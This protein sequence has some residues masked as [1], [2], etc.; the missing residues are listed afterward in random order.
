MPRRQRQKSAFGVHLQL[1]A[2]HRLGHARRDVFLQAVRQR[3]E[4]VVDTLLLDDL[5]QEL[6]RFPAVVLAQKSTHGLERDI[7]LEIQVHVVDE[8]PDQ[9][10]HATPPWGARTST[11]LSYSPR[12]NPGARS[13]RTFSPEPSRTFGG[14]CRSGRDGGC[15][16]AWPIH[17]QF[18]SAI[19]S[20]SWQTRHGRA[21]RR[22]AAAHSPTKLPPCGFTESP[23]RPVDAWQIA[24]SRSVWQLT[25][26]F[27]LRSASQE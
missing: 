26:A 22:K 6:P 12:R 25:Q 15:G 13:L 17:L 10:L 16:Y 19:E 4:K 23:P 11:W 20:S 9:L 24:Q 2:N 1:L 21:F 18:A 3:D 27:K 14:Q 5:G 8:V 7:P